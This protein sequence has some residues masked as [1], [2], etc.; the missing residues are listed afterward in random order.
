MI[1]LRDLL[2]VTGVIVW[3]SFLTCVVIVTHR[4]IQ[5]R[6]ARPVRPPYRDASEPIEPQDRQAVEIAELERM[7]E[8]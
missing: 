6:N 1:F 8:Q 7:W 3:V 4:V 2:I 5:L